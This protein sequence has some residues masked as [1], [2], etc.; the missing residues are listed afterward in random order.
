MSKII[1]VTGSRDFE[2]GQ[3]VLDAIL[4]AK[5][6]AGYETLLVIQGLPAGRTA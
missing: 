5:E 4:A 3:T 6:W 2:D 1:L